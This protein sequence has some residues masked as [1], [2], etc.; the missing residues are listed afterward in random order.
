RE[1]GA[2]ARILLDEQLRINGINK[3]KINGYHNEQTSHYAV[4]STVA[5]GRADVGVGIEQ[6]AKAANIDFIPLI[7]ESYDLVML[8]S[9]DNEAMI[10]DVLATLRDEPFRNSLQSLGYDISGIGDILWEQ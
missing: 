7:T 10:T 2:G 5:S 9:A 3:V 4:V 1:P 8:K 6:T